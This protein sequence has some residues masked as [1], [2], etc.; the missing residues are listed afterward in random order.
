MAIAEGTKE[1][2]PGADDGCFAFSPLGICALGDQLDQR[3]KRTQS[4]AAAIRPTRHGDLPIRHSTAAPA[5]EVL[6]I[7]SPFLGLFRYPSPDL[8][9]KAVR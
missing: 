6:R 9:A 1:P 8:R 2:L 4:C 7:V 5:R 3:L